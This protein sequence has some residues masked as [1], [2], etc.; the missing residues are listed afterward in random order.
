[1]VSAATKRGYKIT[2]DV[3]ISA[4]I[5]PIALPRASDAQK[6]FTGYV[7]IASGWGWTRDSQFIV[8]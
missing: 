5:K 1:M 2:F 6:S 4:Y 3:T 8:L 7:G